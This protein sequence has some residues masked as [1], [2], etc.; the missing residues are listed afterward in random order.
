MIWTMKKITN[1]HYQ[2]SHTGYIFMEIRESII[3]TLRN[4]QRENVET[5][6]AYMENHHFFDR[7]CHRHHKYDGG[8]ADHAWQTYQLAKLLE[9]ENK[10]LYPNAPFLDPNSLAIC[11]LLHDFC[12]CSG[13]HHIKGHG[14]RSSKMLNE[15]GFH[16]SQDEFLA[17]RFHMSLK[18]K[19]YHPLYEAAC[20]C[21][22]RYI[23]HKADHESA[24]MYRGSDSKA[25]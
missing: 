10:R 15:L 22:L 23:V 18:D 17:I 12:N 21:H 24:E 3:E 19:K 6:I 8:L 14:Y 25:Q 16:L 13:M 20:H 7:G 2:Q 9:E 5:V 4:T 11:A 1:D